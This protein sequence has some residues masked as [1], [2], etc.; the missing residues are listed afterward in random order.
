MVTEREAARIPKQ[1]V[2][3]RERRASDTDFQLLLDNNQ[4]ICV[5]TRSKS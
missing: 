5:L 2:V 3:H 4:Q 1:E